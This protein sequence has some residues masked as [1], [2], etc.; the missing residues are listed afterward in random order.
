MK[1]FLSVVSS[2]VLSTAVLLGLVHSVG[3]AVQDTSVLR[4][5]AHT[6]EVV[7]PQGIA[8]CSA[9]SIAPSLL[10]TAAHC[11]G[12]AIRIDGKEAKVLKIDQTH[13]LMLLYAPI[14]C[15]CV[16]VSSQ[17]AVKGTELVT[18][19]YPYGLFVGFVQ[20][21]TKGVVQGFVRG[22]KE[23]ETDRFTGFMMA[24]LPIAGGNSGGGIFAMFNGKWY[25]VSIVSMGA[26][27]IS[28]S[29][30]TEMVQEF[31]K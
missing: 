7:M 9:V 26:D 25:V 20:T 19:G 15:P 29:P 28:I 21:L 5:A 27:G 8:S 18:V 13:D 16:P 14:A 10:L 11:D 3:P 6:L 12:Y 24:T 22:V 30:S 31:V 4:S 2:V 1:Y 17:P 23:Y